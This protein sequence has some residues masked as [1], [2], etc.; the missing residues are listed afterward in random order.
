ML[1]T[2]VAKSLMGVLLSLAIMMAEVAQADEWI[3][4]FRPGDTLWVLCSKY[5]AEPDC[6][7]KVAHRNK[8]VNPRRIAPGTKLYLPIAWLKL[9]PVK[10]KVISV[11]GSPVVELENGETQ[12]IQK[13]DA[14]S[15]GVKLDS[16]DGSFLLEFADGSRLMVKPNS[17]LSFDTLSL[18]GLSGMVDTRVR[19]NRGRVNAK[20][21]PVK[22]RASRYE[23]TTPSAVAAVRGTE[24]RV[25]SIH[26][27]E[28]SMKTEVLE[29][30]VNVGNDAGEQTVAAGYAVKAEKGKKVEQPIALLM[31]PIIVTEIP[32]V[33]T[34]FPLRLKWHAVEGAIAYKLDLFRVSD[35]TDNT[36]KQSERL[37]LEEEIAGVET[38]VQLLAEGK[39]QLNLRAVDDNG[40]EGVDT[41]IEFSVSNPH[42]VL[43]KVETKAEDQQTRW[44]P[45]ALGSAFMLFLIF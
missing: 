37:M 31:S 45:Y 24:F 36:D 35:N 16:R 39:Y 6:W 38:E 44:W 5:I 41:K 33:L 26:G 3:Y 13:G 10:A 19:L 42:E 23:I 32:D 25:T 20:V 28:S 11:E 15:V 9:Q 14:Y 21:T 22:K 40:F 17:E 4:T 7:N 2:T 1:K 29:G 12:V 8:I 18:H 34:L 43:P 27:H 30:S